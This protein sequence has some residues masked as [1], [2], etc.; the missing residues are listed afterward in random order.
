MAISRHALAGPRKSLSLRH[1]FLASSTPQRAV[2]SAS[3][4]IFERQPL[5][6]FINALLKRIEPGMQGSVVQIEDVTEGNEA[7]NPVVGFHIT[8]HR[9]DRV[10][11]PGDNAQQRVH[12]TASRKIDSRLPDLRRLRDRSQ[13]SFLSAE[14]S[15][16]PA[17]TGSRPS[18]GR[19]SAIARLQKLCA[20]CLRRS[21][22]LPH[23]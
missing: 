5:P 23:Y 4:S 11:D 12:S 10:T 21:R 3:S 6:D 8:Q 1:A 22:R 2:A 15:I 20:C 16:I 14:S 17:S 7:E 9:L 19:L 18:R 13:T